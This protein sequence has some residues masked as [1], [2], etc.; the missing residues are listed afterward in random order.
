MHPKNK[1][2]A[3]ALTS[4]ACY[5]TTAQGKEDP[6]ANRS[7]TDVPDDYVGKYTKK[8]RM[9]NYQWEELCYGINSC[10]SHTFCAVTQ[11]EIDVANKAFNQ[12]YKN[13]SEH[14]CAGMGKCSAKKGH[15]GFTYVKKGFCI[16]KH[17]GFYINY[18][19]DRKPVVQKTEKKS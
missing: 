16:K 15:L 4:M 12:R 18:G 7:L 13:S 2:L 6:L 11:K 5:V 1:L 19:K 10:Q 9:G 17:G 8:R 3:L 14:S